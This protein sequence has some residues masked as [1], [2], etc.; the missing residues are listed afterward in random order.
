MRLVGHVAPQ[1][2]VKYFYARLNDRVL[3]ELL[4]VLGL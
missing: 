1:G 4:C 3:Q 2:L